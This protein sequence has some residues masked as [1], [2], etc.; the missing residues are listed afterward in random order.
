M[1][2]EALKRAKKITKNSSFKINTRRIEKH[3]KLTS[4]KI[5]EV[6]GEEVRKKTKAKVDLTN[7][8]FTI[9]IEIMNHKSIH[10]L[11]YNLDPIIYVIP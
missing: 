3:T 8:N 7:P 5:N 2:K 11:K 4:Q 6:L 1:T 9:S 10:L